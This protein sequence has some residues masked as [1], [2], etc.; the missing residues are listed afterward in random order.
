[1]TLR[2]V[3]AKVRWKNRSWGMKMTSV[4]DM[5]KLQYSWDTRMEMFS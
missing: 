2:F 4:F 5:L 3:V 1:M